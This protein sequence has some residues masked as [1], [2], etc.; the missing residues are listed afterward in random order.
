MKNAL[1]RGIKF[2]K[3]KINHQQYSTNLTV[4]N[5][6]DKSIKF[7]FEPQNILG[8]IK[9]ELEANLDKKR[10]IPYLKATKSQDPISN[11][12]N[13]NTRKEVTKNLSKVSLCWKI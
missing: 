9:P 6:L 12:E 3:K 1:K 8:K 2:T 11:E 4:F 10:I 13:I 7:P 5:R